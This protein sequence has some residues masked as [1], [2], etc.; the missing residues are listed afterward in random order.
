MVLQGKICYNRGKVVDPSPCCG[1]G[2][3]QKKGELP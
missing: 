2:V 1:V 3:N